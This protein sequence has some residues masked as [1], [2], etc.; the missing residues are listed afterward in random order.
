MHVGR[1][2]PHRLSL[3]LALSL[4]ASACASSRYVGSISPSGLYANLGYGFTVELS[5]QGLMS[6][7]NVLDPSRLDD[8][9]PTDRPEVVDAP[10]DTDGNGILE[11]AEMAHFHR[12]TLR[13]LA[14][15]STTSTASLPSARMDVDV[16]ILGGVSAKTPLS[17]VA[18]AAHKE[19]LGDG[20]ER[21][22][23]EERKVSS[24]WDALVA[25]GRAGGKAYKIAV[26]DHP[27]FAGEYDIQRR[28]SLRVLLI[29]DQITTPLRRDFIYLLEALTLSRQGGRLS[30]SE[31]R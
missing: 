11:G 24:S 7:W 4:G 20:A 6:R 14:L 2:L 10:L 21:P 23:W 31:Q 9:P 15:S 3:A 17:E 18:A 16:V 30:R 5:H 27:S 26:I 8:A 29:A 12:P 25:E 28:Q 22:V 13:M 1:Q 19:L